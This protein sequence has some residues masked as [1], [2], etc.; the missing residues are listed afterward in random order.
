MQLRE[1]R[2]VVLTALLLT[3][4]ALSFLLE[5]WQHSIA[6]HPSVRPNAFRNLQKQCCNTQ[7]NDEQAHTCLVLKAK[8]DIGS[9]G[10]TTLKF[11]NDT[12]LDKILGVGEGCWA[13]LDLNVRT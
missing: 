1:V 4:S 13:A 11:S 12:A 9:V 7:E 5:L 2:V 10:M 6:Q 8:I 3:L